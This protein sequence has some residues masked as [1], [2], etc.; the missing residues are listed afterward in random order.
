MDLPSNVT[1]SD[2]NLAQ[3]DD[4]YLASVLYKLTIT[5][6]DTVNFGAILEHNMHYLRPLLKSGKYDEVVKKVLQRISPS[7]CIP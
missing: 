7:E 3:T 1:Q 5:R 4:L 2:L 6:V